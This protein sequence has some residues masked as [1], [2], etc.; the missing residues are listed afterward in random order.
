MNLLKT[1][2]ITHES[3]PTFI[4]DIYYGLEDC[5]YVTTDTK[6]SP[7]AENTICIS[8]CKFFI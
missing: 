1:F 2:I 4:I 5:E 6:K 8:D 3:N 7:K